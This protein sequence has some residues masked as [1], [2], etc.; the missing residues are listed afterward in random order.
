MFTHVVLC[1]LESQ[2]LF[3]VLR[4]DSRQTV[5]HGGPVTWS[6]ADMDGRY[7]DRGGRI[8]TVFELTLYVCWVQWSDCAI[9]DKEQDS[10]PHI[11]YGPKTL[12]VGGE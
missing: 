11:H 2:P 3:D 9:V 5:L 12:S 7:R 4:E 10:Q 1:F 8:H 6:N